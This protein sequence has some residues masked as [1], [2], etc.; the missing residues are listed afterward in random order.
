MPPRRPATVLL[1]ARAQLHSRYA[2]RAHATPCTSIPVMLQH[3][4][5]DPTPHRRTTSRHG[6]SSLL[7]ARA[8]WRHRFPPRPPAHAHP[9]PHRRS[10]SRSHSHWSALRGK[11]FPLLRLAKPAAVTG[12]AAGLLAFAGWEGRVLSGWAGE[13]GAGCRRLGMSVRMP[14]SNRQL[15]RCAACR[16]C[17]Q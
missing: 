4:V 2:G 1:L 5:V 16:S 11:L 6:S 13:G 9:H 14:I 12:G 7:G 15:E 10:F 3:P 8:P 17:V